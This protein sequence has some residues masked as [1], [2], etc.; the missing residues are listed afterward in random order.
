M[1]FSSKA[2]LLLLVAALMAAPVSAQVDSNFYIFLC[3]GQSNMAGG[4][5][6]N[7][8]DKAGLLASDC[9]TNT[10]IKTLAFSDCAKTDYSLGCSV[11]QPARVDSVWYTAFQPIQICSEGLSPSLYFARTLLDSLRSDI[12]I[13]LI[14]CALSGMSLDVFIKGDSNFSIPTYAHPTLGNHSP[15]AW[16]LSRLKA[17]QKVGVVKGAIFHQGESGANS[18][19]CTQKGCSLAWIPMAKMI[20]DTIKMDIGAD[21]SKFPFVVGELRQDT[22]TP[23]PCCSSFNKNV[24]SLAK[25]YP[26]CGVASSAGL[27]GNGNDAYHFNCAGMRTLGARYAQ[28]MLSLSSP[29]YLARAGSSGIVIERAHQYQAMKSATSSIKI[30]SLDGRIIG[31]Y[32]G[33]NV[34]NALRNLKAGGV[35]LVTRKLSDGSVATLPYVN[36]SAGTH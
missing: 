16:M 4:G 34:E 2:Q 7:Q 3:F 35:Y 32:A 23:K 5:A 19:S 22:M 14:P 17:A 11:Y 29:S 8:N 9:D 31:S 30:Y 26:H 36:A 27:L 25:V 18:N 24:D 21:T 15:Y 6:G 20:F 13:G 33:T 1:V 28:Q 12:K 10:R